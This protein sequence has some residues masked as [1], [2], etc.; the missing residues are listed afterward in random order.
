MENKC[1]NLYFILFYTFAFSI[2]ILN[3]KI[4]MKQTF[5]FL[6]MLVMVATVLSC[7]KSEP[8]LTPAQKIVGKYNLTASTGTTGSITKDYL[9]TRPACAADDISEF[10]TDG[11]FIISEG[12]TSCTPPR[13]FSS[14]STYALSP[15]AKTLTITSTNNSTGVVRTEIYTVEELTNSILKVAGDSPQTDPN[16]T[17][18]VVRINATFTKI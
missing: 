6:L 2:E 15:D 4:Q 8:E 5:N 9:L 7:K 11:K 12:A 3:P 16:G 17:P 13:S 10:A 18:I 14:S 1:S